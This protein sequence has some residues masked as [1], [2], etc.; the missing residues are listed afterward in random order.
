MKEHRKYKIKE[1][2]VFLSSFMEHI[3]RPLSKT[4][5]LRN[6]MREAYLIYIAHQLPDLDPHEIKNELYR[7]MENPLTSSELWSKGCIYHEIYLNIYMGE[8]E[9]MGDLDP[10]ERMQE[11][12]NKYLSGVIEIKMRRL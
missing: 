11:F 4:D 9:Y 7:L 10:D 5:E 6:S 1:M 2:E 8:D 3:G 12:V